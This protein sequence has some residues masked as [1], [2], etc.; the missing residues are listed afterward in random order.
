MRDSKQEILHFWFLES[1]P[2]QWFQKNEE[3]D[4]LI[5]ER[6]ATIV[7][8]ARDGLCDGWID[9]AEGALALCIVLDQFPRNIFRNSPAAFASDDDA[10][11]VAV[12]AVAKGLDQILPPQR[13]RFLYLPF[14]HSE[15]L[16]DQDKSVALFAGMKDEDP[17]AYEYALRHRDII[18]RFGR[19]PQRNAAL[20]RP[21]SPEEI[22][23]LE[24]KGNDF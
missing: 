9:T 5:R 6:F 19:F 7:A 3:F 4:T 14:G 21:S 22:L 23:Y 1:K 18:Q 15:C 10:L 20:E 24:Q 8:M 17:M 12:Q 11:R 2:A 13:R 16:A